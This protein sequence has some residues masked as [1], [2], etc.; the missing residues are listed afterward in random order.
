MFNLN[1]TFHKID[2]GIFVKKLFHTDLPR[3]LV[4]ILGD[5]LR[6]SYVYVNYNDVND[7]K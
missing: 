4:N 3:V 6:N 2:I 7:N 5:L 1:K